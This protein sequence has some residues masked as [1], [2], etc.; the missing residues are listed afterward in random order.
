MA[1]V[2]RRWHCCSAGSG[3]AFSQQLT[4]HP[5]PIPAGHIDPAGSLLPL[6]PC[7]HRFDIWTSE[8]NLVLTFCS[9][10]QLSLAFW[11]TKQEG[12]QSGR[13]LLMVPVG[14]L[15]LAPAGLGSEHLGLPPWSTLVWESFISWDVIGL[16]SSIPMRSS[17]PVLGGKARAGCWHH[18][19]CWA[20]GE[21]QPLCT[22][23]LSAAQS[24]NLG[25]GGGGGKQ[26]KWSR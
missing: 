9:H 21:P 8:G 25:G 24:F 14:G 2:S 23:L 18:W 7:Q 3:I 13:Q 19:P 12:E 22:L 17:F 10:S 26:L 15:L 1:E 11:E 20:W 6:A 16:Q 5:T 4:L